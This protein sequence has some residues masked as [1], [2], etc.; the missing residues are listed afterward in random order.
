MKGPDLPTR[1]A[2]IDQHPLSF[3][4]HDAV[5]HVSS[6]QSNGGVG[7]PRYYRQPTRMVQSSPERRSRLCVEREELQGVVLTLASPG[8][9]HGGL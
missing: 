5:N 2:V 4:H 6:G 1:G 3:K 9:E 7:Y 8:S